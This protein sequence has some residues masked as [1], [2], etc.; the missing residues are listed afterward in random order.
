[1][2]KAHCLIDN[3]FVNKIENPI[4]SGNIASDISDHFSQ[5]CIIQCDKY[6]NYQYQTNA[7]IRDYSKLPESKFNDDISRINW[8]TIIENK[9]DN[10]DKLFVTFYD[11]LNN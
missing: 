8:Y 10:I 2:R 4:L 5:F 3:I 9:K 7:K 6:I 11:K 1:V